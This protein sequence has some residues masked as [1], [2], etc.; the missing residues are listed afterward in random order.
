MADRTPWYRL[1]HALWLCSPLAAQSSQPVDPDLRA[2]FGFL[3]PRIEKIDDGIN[4]LRV[5]DLDGDGKLEI[6]VNNGRRARLE[7]LRLNGE[8]LTRD[9]VNT[10]GEITGL[11]IGDVDGDGAPDTVTMD[12]RG[13]LQVRSGSRRPRAPRSN[14][15]SWRCKR[16]CDWGT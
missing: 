6:V 11:A 3:G 7:V 8:R 9:S 4:L 1:A 13:R 5:A 12:S 15:V 2:R 10:S 14:S 16:V